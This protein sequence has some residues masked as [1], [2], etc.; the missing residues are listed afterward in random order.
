MS[1]LRIGFSGLP[2]KRQL[3]KAG[4]LAF[5]EVQ[6]TFHQGVRPQTL[7]KRR[8]EL[9]DRLGLVIRAHRDLTFSRKDDPAAGLLRDTETV[10]RAWASTLTSA[11]AARAAA[12][13]L[14]SPADLTP[15]QRHRDALNAAGA[16]LAQELPGTFAIW[17]PRGLW[18]PEELVEVAGEAG[19]IPAFDPLTD[20][21][22]V[23]EGPAFFRLAGP[24]G[25][26]ARYGQED[27]IEILELA[28]ER[29]STWIGFDYE[30][31]IADASKLAGLLVEDE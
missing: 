14:R 16:R 12:V 18:G 22:P 19:F 15:T 2:S 24:G 31:G 6:E 27:L 10:E 13:L 4:T 28:L 8:E 7:A 20:E 5:V 9:P 25:L 1:E 17:E 30:G 21:P 3:K 26:R 29:E 11:R 23:D